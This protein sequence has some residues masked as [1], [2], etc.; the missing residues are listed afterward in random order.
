MGSG[1]G[2]PPRPAEHSPG[3]G[4]CVIVPAYNEEGSVATVVSELR[5]TIRGAEIVVIDDG[6]ADATA[7]RAAAAGAE[8]VSLPLNLGIGGAVQTGYLYALRHGADIAVQVDGDGQHDPHEVPRL[9]EPLRDG[10]ADMAVGSRWLGRGSYRS[11]WGRRFGMRLLSAVV[12]F[13]CGERFTDTTSGFRAVGRAGMCLFAAQYP[14]DFPE[15]ETLVIARRQGL[16]VEEVAVSMRAR[17]H[18]RS[19]IAGLRSAYYMARVILLL[20]AGQPRF[21]WQVGE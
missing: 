4:V 3:R 12:R 18:G 6:S 9:I 13:R 8:V 5:E 11:P 1:G 10:R 20:L 14:S 16:Q 7:T 15:V 19:S 21:D 17:E 2:V